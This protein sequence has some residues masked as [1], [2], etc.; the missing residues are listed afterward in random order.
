MNCFYNCTIECCCVEIRISLH[1]IC[2]SYFL[3]SRV[4]YFGLL[5]TY[6]P[7][8]FN[9]NTNNENVVAVCCC[10]C[11]ELL[12]LRFSYQKEIRK[13]NVWGWWMN[14]LENFFFFLYSHTDA[15]N[16]TKK[17]PIMKRKKK[18]PWLYLISFWLH[19]YIY[20]PTSFVID[21]EKKSRIIERGGLV[22]AINRFE[23]GIASSWGLSSLLSCWGKKIHCPPF[24]STASKPPSIFFGLLR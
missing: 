6:P 8:I 18:K 9:L 2:P 1:Y 23:T 22:Y 15:C 4:R 20:T 10:S 14:A 16:K 21:N 3:Q 19:W 11:W 13:K 17:N 7:Q 12:V 5:F 24:L